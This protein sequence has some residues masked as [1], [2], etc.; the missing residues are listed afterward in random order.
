VQALTGLRHPA[1]SN[2]EAMDLQ[3]YKICA[4]QQHGI[5]SSIW[6]FNSLTPKSILAARKNSR[7][8]D[9]WLAEH[10][11]TCIP[12]MMEPFSPPA[13]WFLWTSIHHAREP[14][15]KGLDEAVVKG[16]SIKL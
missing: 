5:R 9:F 12:T 6:S 15:R 7:S 3:H 16:F 11:D 10:K 13:A 4:Q 1:A 8:E 14:T 2:N